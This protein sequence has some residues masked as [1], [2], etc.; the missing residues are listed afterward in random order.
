MKNIE[1]IKKLI[2]LY[3]LFFLFCCLIVPQQ[4]H[5][6][7]LY[8]W[9]N[10]T[11]FIFSNGLQNIYES[12]TDYLPL[13]F[14]ALKIF[15]LLQGNVESIDKNIHYLKLIT[16]LFHFIGGFFL[17]LWIK[18]K[19]W[20]STK[21]TIYLLYYLLN[22]AILY[23]TIIWGQIDEILAV[24]VLITCYFSFKQNVH[25]ALIFFVLSINLKL[26]AIIFLPIVGLSLLPAV[27]SVFSFRRIIAY[28]FTTL[29]VQTVIILPFIL[30]GTYLEIWKV[31][32]GSMGKYPFVS[33][34]AY[35]FWEF[36]LQGNLIHLLDS[37]K[38][39]GISY[40]VW[41]LF[42][43]TSTSG[44]ALFPL[45]KSVYLSIQSKVQLHFPLEKYLLLCG[46]IPLLFFYF[47]TQM[48][49]RYSHPTLIFLIAYSLYTR[50][51][52]VS[53]IVT[54]AYFLNL[55]GVLQFLNF[56]NYESLVFSKDFI[57]FLYLSSIIYIYFQLFNIKFKSTLFGVCDSLLK[58]FPKINYPKN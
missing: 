11:K 13:Y 27:I 28:I 58:L 4:G 46:V 49:E 2:P 21:M 34:N 25:L 55:E 37:N 33:M 35:N 20:N 8:C 42:F 51:L 48:H 43:F 44:L 40:K 9:R 32:K 6:Y 38:I 56:S 31:I 16:L 57:S 5:P 3:I 36:L 12:D 1:F 54:F 23:N 10:W 45:M 53:I 30:S 29:L 7:D 22:I 47:N 19:N 41:G 26:Q 52:F 14:Y 50:K 15:G 17:M 24:L 39:I 18:E